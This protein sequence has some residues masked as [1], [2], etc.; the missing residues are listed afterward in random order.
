MS[1]RTKPYHPIIAF[2]GLGLIQER[3]SS[4]DKSRDRYS[5]IMHPGCIRGSTTGLVRGTQRRFIAG[6]SRWL[7][8]K[9]KTDVSIVEM[10]TTDH[11]TNVLGTAIELIVIDAMVR[12]QTKNCFVPH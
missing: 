7:L 3:N 1:T 4:H 12:L 2:Q 5:P 9:E 10:K 11:N 8:Q 6:G